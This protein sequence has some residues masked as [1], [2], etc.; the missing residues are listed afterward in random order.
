MI[1]PILRPAEPERD[2]GQ[3]A[4]LFSS[5][6]DE[7]TSEPGLKVDYEEHKERIFRLV[8]AEDEQGE[9]LGFNWATRS[10]FDPSHAYFYLIVKPEQRGQGVGRRLYDDLV[11][12]AVEA[13]VKNLQVS[14]QDTC[15][16]G[17]AFTEQRGFT[18]QSH[19]IGLAL[20][21]DAFDDQPYDAIIARLKGEGFQF[22][23]MD[24]LGN[25]EEVQRKLYLLNDSTNMEMTVPDDEHSWLSFEDFQAKVCQTDWYKPG[26]QIVAIDS[27]S[28]AWAAMSA[29]TRFEGSDHAYNLHTG[30]DRLYH[31]RKLAQA[32]LVLALRYARE[33]LKVNRAH[34]DENV[35]N[36]PSI[37]IYR[38]LGYTQMPGS[39]SMEKIL[40]EEK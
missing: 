32:V 23:S 36:L 14:V 13:Q 15:Q 8:V 21:L 18:E 4:A 30:I 7:P 37:A 17:L 3:L 2:F 38:E 22:T 19:Y 26:G 29:I 33:V 27:A 11:Q 16:E 25:T 28:G 12:A 24:K 1:T 20:D 39:I 9:L 40:V 31:R 34:A 10:R 6:Q 35:L 5:H